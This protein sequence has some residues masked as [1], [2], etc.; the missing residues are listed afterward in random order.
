MTYAILSVAVLGALALVC[1]HTLR[2]LPFGPLALTA[3]VL[4]VL[5]AVFDNVIVGLHIVAYD[6][7]RILGLLVPIAPIEDFAYALGAVMLVPTVWTLLG[8]RGSVG[9]AT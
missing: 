1:V 8:R 2:R 6:N 9:A 7:A 4:V 5:T 3:V